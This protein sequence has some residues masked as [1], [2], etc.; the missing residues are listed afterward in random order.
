MN[1][2]D[3]SKAC[4]ILKDMNTLLSFEGILPSD[5]E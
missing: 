2:S 5:E 1:V 4:T 3:V